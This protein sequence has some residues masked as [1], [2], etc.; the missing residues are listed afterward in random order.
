MED[1]PALKHEVTVEQAL[2]LPRRG[3]RA[4]SDE[5]GAIP[6]AAACPYLVES[7]RPVIFDGDM[8]PSSV[9]SQ[10]LVPERWRSLG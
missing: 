6:Y 2:G 10:Q 9:G 5:I 4:R 3:L 7:N 1:L 8:D